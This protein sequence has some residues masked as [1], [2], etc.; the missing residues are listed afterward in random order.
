M[1]DDREAGDAVA[2]EA[3]R[4]AV[5]RLRAT[6][7][8]SMP[9]QPDAYALAS[10]RRTI[11]S[12]DELVAWFVGAAKPL[13][14][15][16][17]A[18][19]A[20]VIVVLSDPP[21]QGTPIYGSSELAR[22]KFE[23]DTRDPSYSLSAPMRSFAVA[24]GVQEREATVPCLRTDGMELFSYPAVDRWEREYALIPDNWAF[25]SLHELADRDQVYVKARVRGAVCILYL[26]GLLPP[27]S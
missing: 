15:R 13:I 27:A 22:R 23:E 24:A 21:R 1:T 8:P 17:V 7:H 14:Y 12:G 19:S 3:A 2:W 4:F 18:S 25:R 6:I 11:L 5:F 16:G 9:L 20:G 10:D 26:S